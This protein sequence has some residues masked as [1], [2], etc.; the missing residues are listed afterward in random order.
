MLCFNP[1]KFIQERSDRQDKI[2]S[3]KKYL[4]SKN[5]ELAQ[6]KKSR[7]R[8]LLRENLT[9]YLKKRQVQ[10]MFKFRLLKLQK[11][12]VRTFQI[13]YGLREDKIKEEGLLDGIY[14]VIDQ[15]YSES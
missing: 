8:Q 2:A 12:R 1:E 15:S 10:W 4:D 5:K 14:V 11:G 6:A 9:A 7:N 13:R 3:V